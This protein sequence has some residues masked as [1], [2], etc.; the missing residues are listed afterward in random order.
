MKFAPLLL[1]ILRRM[2]QATPEQF[3]S[4]VEWVKA[5]QTAVV[6]KG[7]G[8][9]RKAWVRAQL[10]AA[11]PALKGFAKD[12][13]VAAAYGYAVNKGILPPKAETTP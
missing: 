9:E 8:E 4:A 12:L 7:K 5:A 3:W 13:L 1:F 2:A 11:A 10:E 6:G